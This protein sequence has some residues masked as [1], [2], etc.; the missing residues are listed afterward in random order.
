MAKAG[1][2]RPKWGQLH[3]L[4]PINQDPG[5]PEYEAFRWVI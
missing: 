4:L 2:Q 1:K 5:H 3:H